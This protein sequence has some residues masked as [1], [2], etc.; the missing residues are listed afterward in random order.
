MKVKHLAM[1]AIAATALA[2][3]FA[4]PAPAAAQT[5]CPPAGTRYISDN[6]VVRVEVVSMGGEMNPTLGCQWRRQTDGEVIWLNLGATMTPVRTAAPASK[7]PASKAPASKA[8]A[9]APGVLPVGVYECDA[10]IDV[11]GMM[12]GSPQTGLMFGVTGPGAYRDYNGGTGRF[13]LAGNLLTMTSGPLQ[14]Q[15]YRREGERLFKPLNAAGATGPIRC[16]FNPAKR[17]NSRW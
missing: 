7:A 14:G 11:G 1:P 17:L 5:A 13:A 10:P 4:A 3:L 12:M 16:I 2:A 15:R 6:F 8:P 9:G